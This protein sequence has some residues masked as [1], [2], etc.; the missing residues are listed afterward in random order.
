MP[1]GS[2][3]SAHR[4]NYIIYRIAAVCCRLTI[5]KSTKST[6]LHT[7]HA[8]M[9][10]EARAYDLHRTV[11]KCRM[12]IFDYIC[13]IKH[14]IENTLIKWIDYGNRQQQLLGIIYVCSRAAEQPN[15]GLCETG[16]P[17][18]PHTSQLDADIHC[19]LQCIQRSHFGSRWHQINLNIECSS[20]RLKWFA[21]CR[22]IFG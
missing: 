20:H 9:Y 5:F 2:R 15:W 16:A 6:N 12:H 17:H 22:L 21:V 10:V 8:Y 1:V 7:Q 14:A 19:Y 18:L 13:L 4:N 11:T 3:Q